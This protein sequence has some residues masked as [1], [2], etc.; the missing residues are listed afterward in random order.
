M[1][2]DI[3]PDKPTTLSAVDL[4][5]VKSMAATIR[6]A[7][8]RQAGGEAEIV[9]EKVVAKLREEEPKP[10][11]AEPELLTVKQAA[12]VL[13][14]SPQAVRHR[15][16]SESFPARLVVRLGGRVMFVRAKLTAWIA[17]GAR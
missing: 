13:G 8:L 15:L 6:E 16:H 14:I 7:V 5:C 4:A 1:D 11:I 10:P 9:A 3:K 2:D 12:V 17:G